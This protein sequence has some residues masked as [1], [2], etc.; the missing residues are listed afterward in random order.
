MYLE[1]PNA[2]NVQVDMAVQDRVGM[3][4]ATGVPHSVLRQTAYIGALHLNS[5]QSSSADP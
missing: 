4:T 3:Y 5:W 2:R 1:T